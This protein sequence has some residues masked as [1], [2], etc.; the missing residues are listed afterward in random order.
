MTTIE[1]VGW[2]VR[3][4]RELVEQLQQLYTGT[5]TD[6]PALGRLA[7]DAYADAGD[8]R[9]FRRLT[10]SD[11]FARRRADADVVLTA[12]PASDAADG[13]ATPVPISL[14]P[15]EAAALLRTLNALRLVISVRLDI[16][17]DDPHDA[18]DPRFGVYDWLGFRLDDLVT[19]LAD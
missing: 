7:P 13:D 8:A 18:G 15:S 11:A 14:D 19:R 9:E 16:T 17:H 12:L 5:S 1:L 6:D 2:E 4:L 10:A 3:T